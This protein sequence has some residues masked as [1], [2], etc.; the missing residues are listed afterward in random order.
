MKTGCKT[1][2]WIKTFSHIFG[3]KSENFLKKEMRISR[4]HLVFKWELLF[5]YI[6]MTVSILVITNARVKV[7]ANLK[8]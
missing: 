8:L 6:F 7:P 1:E 5:H 3:R 2:E 4:K